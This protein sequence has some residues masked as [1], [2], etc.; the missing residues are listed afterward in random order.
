MHTD[1]MMISLDAYL[2][3]FCITQ[4]AILGTLAFIASRQD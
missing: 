2:I 3:V 1:D 4:G